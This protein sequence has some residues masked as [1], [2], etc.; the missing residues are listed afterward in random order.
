M[1]VCIV[2]CWLSVRCQGQPEEGAE[3]GSQE[4]PRPIAENVDYINLLPCWEFS[5]TEAQRPER[6]VHRH[7]DDVEAEASEVRCSFFTQ[8]QNH[9]H[10]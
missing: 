10:S 8:W 3:R 7:Y 5:A 6:L 1:Y 9:V 2:T 4:G